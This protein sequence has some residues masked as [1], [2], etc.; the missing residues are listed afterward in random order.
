MDV[1]HFCRTVFGDLCP[2]VSVC[3]IW[4]LQIVS[5]LSSKTLLSGEK[6][7]HTQ[8]FIKRNPSIPDPRISTGYDR[9]IQPLAVP[10]SAF[11]KPHKRRYD[12]WQSFYIHFREE[13]QI[14][15]CYP[16]CT[17]QLTKSVLLG[18]FLCMSNFI[19]SSSSSLTGLFSLQI[20]KY[21]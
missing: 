9:P 11:Y 8:V 6:N 18:P 14:R 2:E 12:G 7:S 13:T 17:F 21:K 5:F 15:R 4:S 16:I 10:C 19:Y 20:Y 3:A 1:K